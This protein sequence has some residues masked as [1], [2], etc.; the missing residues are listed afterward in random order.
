MSK[1]T[2]SNKA[3]RNKSQFAPGWADVSQVFADRI[4]VYPLHVEWMWWLWCRLTALS[5]RLDRHLQ[6]PSALEFFAVEGEIAAVAFGDED[7]VRS[8]TNGEVAMIE[9]LSALE[10]Q[11]SS[12]S[13]RRIHVR[14]ASRNYARAVPL[15]LTLAGGQVVHFCDIEEGVGSTP[16][17]R[18]DAYFQALV[19]RK[20]RAA[21]YMSEGVFTAMA[22]R[23]NAAS[24]PARDTTKYLWLG[25]KAPAIAPHTAAEAMEQR[26]I[27]FGQLCC[28]LTWIYS[29]SAMMFFF[30]VLIA[31]RGDEITRDVLRVTALMLPLLFVVPVVGRVA[32]PVLTL[33]KRTLT[34]GGK[35][36]GPLPPLPVLMRTSRIG[37]G[38]M[39]RLRSYDRGCMTEWLARTL[40]WPA[41][42]QG[43][44]HHE[45]SLMDDYIWPWVALVLTVLLWSIAW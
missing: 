9:V 10:T 35:D 3:T 29:V 11:V 20:V 24:E 28:G 36:P 22:L 33:L 18:R 6:R 12:D 2:R 37:G 40:Q 7:V 31:G 44:R 14:P 21:G 4:D 16:G 1:K 38:A 5:G 23:A 19:G 43:V 15:T 30:G 45:W 17:M 39:N 27:G 34:R 41:A 32:W 8:D 25:T 42:P 26:T 13:Y